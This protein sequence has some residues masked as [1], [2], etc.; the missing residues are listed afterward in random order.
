[1]LLVGG[2]VDHGDLQTDFHTDFGGDI[3]TDLGGDVHSGFDAQLDADHA[4]SYSSFKFLSLQG[5]TAF[6][7]MFGLVGLALIKAEIA[8]ILTI[9]GGAI[10]GLFTVWIIS[11]IFAQMR[12]LQSEGTLDIQ[13]AIGE[14]GSVYLTVPPNASG[15]VQLSVQG[16]MRILDA[17][18]QNNK[19]IATGTKVRVVE[20]VNSSTVV[21]EKI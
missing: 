12:H 14:V 5:L 21:V 20:V 7:M 13:N 11:I 8:I 1:M 3:H 4:D 18:S 10:A 15:Q 6:F 19:K 9:F 17:V 16:A 2:G